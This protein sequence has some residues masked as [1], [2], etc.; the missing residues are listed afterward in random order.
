M[1]ICYTKYR[2]LA[3]FNILENLKILIYQRLYKGGTYGI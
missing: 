2:N 1:N 3:K